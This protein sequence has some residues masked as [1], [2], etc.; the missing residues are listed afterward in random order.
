MHMKCEAALLLIWRGAANAQDGLPS[1]LDSST[2]KCFANSIARE[3][4]GDAMQL[5]GAYG[6]SKELPMERRLRDSWGW[7]VA[8]GAIYILTVHNP[9]A[10]L[11]RRLSQRRYACACVRATTYHQ[12]HPSRHPLPLHPGRTQVA[13]SVST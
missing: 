7:G 8:G 1:I 13:V 5:M 11:G 12:E 10:I 6:Y 9:V 4:A 3:V 2:A